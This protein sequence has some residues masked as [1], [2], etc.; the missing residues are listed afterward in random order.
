MYDAATNG[1]ASI[2][3]PPNATDTEF[4]PLPDGRIGALT[5]SRAS[6]E[7]GGITDTRVWLYDPSSERYEQLGSRH[8]AIS[9]ISIVAGIAVLVDMS[10]SHDN[11]E[12]VVVVLGWDGVDRDLYH[13]NGSVQNFAL[14]PDASHIAFSREAAGLGGNWLVDLATG[15]ETRLPDG[16]IDPERGMRFSPDGTQVALIF[17]D[18]HSEAYDLDGSTLTSIASPTVGWF[19]VP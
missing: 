5:G 18:G 16:A 9:L 4:A 19:G 8:D 14:A 13:F 1:F 6:F 2:P 12:W 7:F 17:A 11:S 10:P 3:Q 15:S